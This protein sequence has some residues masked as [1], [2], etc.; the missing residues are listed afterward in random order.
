M[1]FI[2]ATTG[3]SSPFTTIKRTNN[4]LETEA[5]TLIRLLD[6]SGISRAILFGHSDG[7]SIALIAAAKYPDRVQAVITEGAHIFVEGI[8]LTGI[9]DAVTAWQHTNLRSKLEKYHG[10]SPH[11]ESSPAVLVSTASFISMHVSA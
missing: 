7:G 4:Y 8:T 3:L 9:R 11:K 6:A 10:H 5:D 2:Q 1:R